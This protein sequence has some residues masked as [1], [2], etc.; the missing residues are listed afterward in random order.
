MTW[1]LNCIIIAFIIYFSYNALALYNFGVPYSLSKTYYLFEEK[2]KWMR[3]LF[4]IM[5]ISVAALLTPAWLTLSVGSTYQFTA[6]LAPLGVMFVG[7]CPTFNGSKM[8]DRVHTISAFFAAVMALMWVILVAGTWHFIL[9][10]SLLILVLSLFTK[11]LKSG[12][13]YWLETIVFMSTFMSMLYC[14]LI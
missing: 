8:E 4:P 7:A 2:K 1:I 10:W 3:A 14:V 9:F 5:M 12:I 6:F 13:V 11:T